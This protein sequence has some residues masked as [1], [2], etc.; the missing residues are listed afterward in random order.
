MPVA[1]NSQDVFTLTEMGAKPQGVRIRMTRIQSSR[2]ALPAWAVLAFVLVGG[3]SA[4]A[5]KDAKPAGKL[6]VGDKAP[7]L[8]VAHWIKGEQVDLSSLQDRG[9]AVI[10]FWATWCGP[11]IDSIPH[12]SELQRQYGGR[13]VKVIGITSED[14]RNTL[15]AV[16]DFVKDKGDKI[17]YSIAFDDKN[18]SDEAWMQAAEQKGIP[19]AFIV[20]K[21]GRIAWIGHP[22][23]DMETTIE[24]ILTGRF[25]IEKAKKVA[26]IQEQLWY[27]DDDAKVIHL[28]DEW[29]KLRPGDLEPY[30][31]K[32]SRYL[33]SLKDLTKARQT[34][35][36]MRIAFKD[37]A[38]SLVSVARVI[39]DRENRDQFNAIAEDCLNRA[40][41]LDARNVDVFIARFRLLTYEKKFEAATSIGEQAIGRLQREPKRLA[42]LASIMALP[43]YGNRFKSQAVR[44]VDAAIRAK[45]EAVGY[46]TSKLYILADSGDV[47]GA[48][49]TG[50]QL[51]SVPEVDFATLNALAW[52]LLTESPYAGKYDKLALEAVERANT[53]TKGE[54]WAILDTLATAQFKNGDIDKAIATQKKVLDKLD[55]LGKDQW[56]VAECKQR[57]KEFE[58]AKKDKAAK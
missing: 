36:A 46:I 53:L 32:F 9:V 45:P 22:M 1:W 51:L 34:A 18:K 58:E 55:K 3:S 25:D 39:M 21:E 8:H 6:G 33:N 37:R 44:A 4:I 24:E 10:E 48:K 26:K 49:Q 47:A 2:F 27:E 38:P 14:E 35:T 40:A 29:I 42:E 19:T 15:K 28:A 31:L 13:G 16:R 20:D 12:L 23:D 54:D 57:L 50:R 5:Q 17:Q 11:C 41:R 7:K 56:A 43:E 52:T 30:S